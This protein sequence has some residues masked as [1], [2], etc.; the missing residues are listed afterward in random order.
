MAFTGFNN[1]WRKI[2]TGLWFICSIFEIDNK[3]E[4]ENSKNERI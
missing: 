2:S 3:S 1:L 4:S